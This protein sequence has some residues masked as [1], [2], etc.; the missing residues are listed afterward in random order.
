MKS[1][2]ASLVKNQREAPEWLGEMFYEST[3]IDRRIPVIN[4]SVM[5][6]KRW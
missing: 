6:S 5:S 4:A 2:F 3:K 1:C